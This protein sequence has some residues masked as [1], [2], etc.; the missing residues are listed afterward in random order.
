MRFVPAAALDAAPI[1]VA[2]VTEKSGTLVTAGAR[3]WMLWNSSSQYEIGLEAIER[4]QRG[5]ATTVPM[6]QRFPQ[7]VGTDLTR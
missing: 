6:Q 1:G 5:A 3:G 4:Y 7:P 2:G